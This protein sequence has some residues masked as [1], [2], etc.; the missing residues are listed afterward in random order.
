MALEPVKLANGNIL[1]PQRV[2]ADDG[3]IGDIF[4][5]ITPNDLVYELWLPYVEPTLPA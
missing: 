1:A 5:E 4:V 2:E 3:T